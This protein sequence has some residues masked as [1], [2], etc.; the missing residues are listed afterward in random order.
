MTQIDIAHNLHLTRTRMLNA[1]REYGRDPS[2]IHLLAVSKTQPVSAL[3]AAIASGQ[4]DFGENY[5]QDALEKIAALAEQQLSWHFIGAIQ[6]N[7]TR[8]LAENFAW[9]ETLASLKHAKR[10]NE[11]RPEHLPALNVCIQVNISAEPQKAGV[12]VAE[13]SD[14]ALA[15][16]DMPRL[17]LRGLLSIPA[18]MQSFEQQRKPHRALRALLESLQAQGLKLDTLSMGMSGDM[19]AAIAEGATQVRIG[20]A[21]FG[22]R[23]VLKNKL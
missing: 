1:A 18:P 10:L 12:A 22:K 14:L 21:I 15:I 8:P 7:K 2:Q 23:K 20:T 17:Q 11:Q 3:Q 13:V 9:V 16:A 6:S 4:K 5:L 19:D